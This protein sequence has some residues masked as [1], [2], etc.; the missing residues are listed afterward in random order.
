MKNLTAWS[1]VV[2]AVVATCGSWALAAEAADSKIQS[3]TVYRGQA[4]VTRTVTTPAQTGELELIVDELPAQILPASLSASGSDGI[5]VRAVRYR[6]EAAA[7]AEKK[8]VAELDEQIKQLR[9]RQEEQ[10]QVKELLKAKAAHLGKLEGFAAPTA[11]VEM[12]KGVL[13]TKV[14][15]EVSQYI[16]TQR[17]ELTKQQITLDREARRLSE[18]LELLQRKRSELA[19]GRKD[20]APGGGVPDQGRR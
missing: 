9:E 13:D 14:L 19:R 11:S 5:A 15:T 1:M 4:L 12:S 16:L 18:E 6:A 8:E 3:V 17:E 2:L 7:A 20:Q 10:K